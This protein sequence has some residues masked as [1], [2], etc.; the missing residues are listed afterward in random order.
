[1]RFENVEVRLRNRRLGELGALQE[2]I[3]GLDRI[4]AWNDGNSDPGVSDSLDP[5][6]ENLDIVEHLCEDDGCAG[7]NLLL[8]PL[9]F[10]SE[11]LMGKCHM[12]WEAWDRDLEVIPMVLSDMS[13]E[14]DSVS[15]ATLNSCPGILTSRGV[16]AKSENVPAAL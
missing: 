6:D 1:V 5:I 9:E 10:L 15:K 11:F 8:E 14:I 2:A 3:P 16:A 12:L 4:D 7:I 13:N